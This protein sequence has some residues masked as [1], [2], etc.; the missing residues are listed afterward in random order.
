MTDTGGTDPDAPGWGGT[1]PNAGQQQ[2]WGAPPPPGQWGQQPPPGQWGQQPP[3]G[4]GG[5][6]GTPPGFG[7][8]PGY[9]AQPGYGAPPAGYGG[10]YG[11]PP[12]EGKAVG[13]LI[14]AILSWFA[15]P[16][17]LAI[18]ALVL[19]NQSTT[20]IR[21][22]GG[23]LGGEGM[24]TAARVIAWLNIGLSALFIAFFVFA[25]LAASN[26]TNY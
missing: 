12:N 23:R 9:G 3:P 10:Y 13:A 21:N 18:V 6:Y 1:D 25:A 15:C 7:P 19:A 8:P 5:G 24:N 26:T 16:L 20:E 2:P 11:S 22:S 17:I 14:C 4:Y